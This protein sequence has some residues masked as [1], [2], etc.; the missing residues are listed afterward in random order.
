MGGGGGGDSMQ[1]NL[2]VNIEWAQMYVNFIRIMVR[3]ESE[4]SLPT[5][6]LEI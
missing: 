5:N 3:I 4:L 2:S 6:S 1:P